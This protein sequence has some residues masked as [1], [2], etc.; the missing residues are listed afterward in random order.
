MLAEPVLD[1][2]GDASFQDV[3]AQTGLSVDGTV[4]YEP[5]PQREVVDSHDTGYFEPGERITSMARSAVF[6]ETPTPRAGSNFTE[7]VPANSRAPR[8]PGPSAATWAAGNGPGRRRPARGRPAP[9]SQEPGSASGAPGPSPRRAEPSTRTSPAV[10]SADV[11]FGISGTL[12]PG[13]TCG[14]RAC[15]PERDHL[16]QASI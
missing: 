1:D 16:A 8:R 9:S 3:D 6:P 14:R 5:A 4:A 12:P 15:R 11:R 2:I 7:A 13:A 10:R